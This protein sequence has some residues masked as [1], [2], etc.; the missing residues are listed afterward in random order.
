MDLWMLSVPNYVSWM[1][2]KMQ[3]ESFKIYVL[4]MALLAQRR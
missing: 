1:D 2:L 3:S 4:P